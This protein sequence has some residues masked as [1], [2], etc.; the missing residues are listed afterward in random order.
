MDEKPVV[1]ILHGDDSYGMEQYVQS[2]VSRMGDP[3]L[4]DLN[5]ARLDGRSTSEEELRTAALSI[6]FLAERRLVVMVHPL[7]KLGAAANQKRFAA[8]LDGLP[9]TTALILLVE[10]HF[11]WDRNAKKYTWEVLKEKHWLMAWAAG[12]GKRAHV[13]EFSL[14]KPAEMP[15]WIQKQARELKGQFSPQAA[16]ALA[17][18]IGSDTQLASREIEKLLVYVDYARPVE[19]EDVQDCTAVVSQ[20]NVFEMVDA[21]AE[22]NAPRALKLMHTLLEEEEAIGLF[23]IIVGHFRVLLLAR[24]FQEEGGSLNGFLE[25]SH[26]PRFVAEKAYRQA[27]RFGMEELTAIYRRLVGMD[28]SLKNGQTIPDV[29][30]ETF[31]AEVGSGIRKQP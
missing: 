28:E 29:A 15:E 6:P 16:A 3:G 30:L 18:L 25:V 20:V 24:E 4:A 13:R 22:G 17:N 12:A 23:A 26:R 14:P 8:L 27:Q 10:D 2:V 19:A 7:A 1:F 9:Q 31:A 5:T 11:G 21:L